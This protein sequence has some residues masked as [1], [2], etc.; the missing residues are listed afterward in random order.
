MKEESSITFVNAIANR[1]EAAHDVLFCY[2]ETI[3]GLLELLTDCDKWLL[4]FPHRAGIRT[5]KN[6]SLVFV[7]SPDQDPKACLVS[8]MPATGTLTVNF[9]LEH[10]VS[11]GVASKSGAVKEWLEREQIYVTLRKDSSNA[12]VHTD[13]KP[14]S[15]AGHLFHEILL[16]P[17]CVPTLLNAR[18]VEL[19]YVEDGMWPGE[20]TTVAAGKVT[21][22]LA[23]GLA[24]NMVYRLASGSTGY[25][26]ETNDVSCILSPGQL[27]ADSV[28]D[29]TGCFAL[30]ATLEMVGLYQMPWSGP[31]PSGQ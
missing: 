31:A 3:D 2:E 20:S 25:T 5:L 18:P 10:Y 15:L 4:K 22:A 29:E 7:D 28:R 12:Y 1:S 24:T 11:N 19:Q 6:V 21:F 27:A 16:D 14:G 13:V 8:G 17:S 23:P 9:N 30:P 26:G